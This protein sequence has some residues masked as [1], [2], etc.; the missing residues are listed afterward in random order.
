MRPNQICISSSS[1]LCNQILDLGL[2]VHP[3]AYLRD[4]WNG[5]DSLV[6][7]CALISFY[8]Q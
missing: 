3:G 2:I 4:I 5:M 7:S 6:V 1:S 8:F